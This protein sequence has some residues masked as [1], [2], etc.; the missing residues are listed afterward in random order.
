MWYSAVHVSWPVEDLT[1]LAVG[2]T[3]CGEVARGGCSFAFNFSVTRSRVLT[4]AERRTRSNMT[5]S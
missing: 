4:E 1:E 5:L 2:P 3:G